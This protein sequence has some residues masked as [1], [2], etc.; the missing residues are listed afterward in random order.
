MKPQFLLFKPR[1]NV[2]L[3][4]WIRGGAE[5]AA[6]LAFQ[7]QYPRGFMPLAS[8]PGAQ[9]QDLGQICSVYPSSL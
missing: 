5:E 4:R 3:K 9:R 7:S 2:F 1:L 8:S 6:R